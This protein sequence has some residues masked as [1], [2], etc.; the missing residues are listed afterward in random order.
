M[1]GSVVKQLAGVFCLFLLVACNTLP[2]GFDQF[3]NLPATEVLELL[4]DSI[5]CYAKYV[6]LGFADH[7]LLGKDNQYESRVL[8]KFPLRDSSLDSVA[9]IHLILYHQDS[10]PMGFICRACSTDWSTSAVTWRMA[11][12]ITQWFSPGGDWWPFLLGEGKLEGDSTVVELN[13]DYLDTLVHRSSGIILLPRDTGFSTIATLSTSTTAPRLIFNYL[14]GRKRIYYATEDAH[15]I[16]S[17]G[18]GLLPT[19]L[20]VG[21]GVAVRTWL[22]FALESIPRAATIARA[23]ISFQPRTLYRR[24]D[25]LWLAAHR[26]TESYLSRGKSANFDET[27]SA[28]SAY[29]PGDNDTI[30]RIEITALVQNWVSRT[31]SFPNYGLLLTAQP[32]WMKPFR[33]KIFRTGALAP[34]LKI[35]YLLP[36]EDRFSR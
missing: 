35:Q 15:I 11:D 30:V 13:I 19:D 24:T 7:L 18:I 33:F 12:S 10:I 27:P 36:P 34:K 3:E 23:E 22:H 29:V 26:L 8:L 17:I 1:I 28:T 20:V 32:E 21:S 14:D 31:D 6:P 2:V 9:S 25:T 4:P 16:D 5:D